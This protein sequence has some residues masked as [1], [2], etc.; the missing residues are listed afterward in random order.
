MG[1]APLE[2]ERPSSLAPASPGK[3]RSSLSSW[4]RL[5]NVPFQASN[6]VGLF[7][8]GP[9]AIPPQLLCPP[10]PASI[11]ATLLMVQELLRLGVV[12]PRELG[13][14]QV[15]LEARDLS[16]SHLID[17]ESGADCTVER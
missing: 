9:E 6:G 14:A 16:H 3:M 7:H 11:L 12:H 13:L 1:R 4:H 17:S 5:V 2:S 10:E 8:A 15:G